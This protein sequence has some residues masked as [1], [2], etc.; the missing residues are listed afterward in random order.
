[1]RC[2]YFTQIC[3][4]LTGFGP[5]LTAL[6]SRLRRTN[7]FVHSAREL[8]FCIFGKRVTNSKL[9]ALCMYSSRETSVFLFL[10]HHRWEKKLTYIDFFLIN[11]ICRPNLQAKI[12]HNNYV[13]KTIFFKCLSLVYFNLNCFQ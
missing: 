5:L 4:A 6:H 2:L 11:W 9:D 10:L 12:C 8:Y 7:L 1:M 13:D 3:Q